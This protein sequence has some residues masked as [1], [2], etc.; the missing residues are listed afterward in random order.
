MPA[1]FEDYKIFAKARE[2]GAVVLTKD[3]ERAML[4]ARQTTSLPNGR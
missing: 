3:R 1:R 4:S 2:A